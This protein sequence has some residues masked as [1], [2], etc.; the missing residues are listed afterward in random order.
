MYR[1]GFSREG[2]FGAGAEFS[3]KENWSAQ[4]P[5]IP[6]RPSS[7]NRVEAQKQFTETRKDE[8]IK[9]VGNVVMAL[10]LRSKKI[11][12]ALKDVLLTA[13]SSPDGAA[14]LEGLDNEYFSIESLAGQS[15]DMDNEDAIAGLLTQY[16][17]QVDP[18]SRINISRSIEEL[19]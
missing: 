8:L 3:G 15:L 12:S 10:E 5:S 2:M 6:D 19:R 13:E 18:K 14:I 16:K 4:K 7:L 1:E 11:S 17:D 9:K